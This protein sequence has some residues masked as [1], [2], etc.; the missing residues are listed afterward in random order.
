LP[1]T[2]SREDSIYQ[3]SVQHSAF[4]SST[5]D[6]DNIDAP[7]ADFPGFEGGSPINNKKE[8]AED[9]YDTL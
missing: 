7:P 4:K 1:V 8:A 9:P 5:V 2:K 3:H 6:I